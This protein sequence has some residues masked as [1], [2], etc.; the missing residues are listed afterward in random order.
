M[1]SIWA[2]VSDIHG[3]LPALERALEHARTEGAARVAFL[4]DVLGGAQDEA[5]CRLLMR[6]AEIG[7]FG[8][9][10]VRARLPFAE[11]VQA[12]LHSLTATARLDGLLLCH[13]SP[14][15]LFPPDISAY[16]AVAYKRGRSYFD[17]FPYISSKT[18]IRTA[19]CSQQ[20][21]MRAVVHGHTHRQVIWRVEDGVPERLREREVSLG[22]GV[23]VAGLGSVGEGERGRVEYGLYFREERRLR[24]VSLNGE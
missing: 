23:L 3:N 22:E 20:E 24:L 18:S 14:A 17:L 8:N 16:D 5:C 15:S 2:L 1:D 12:W 7:V 6:E 10:E 11:D 19:A 4:G 9:R 13:S 21:G